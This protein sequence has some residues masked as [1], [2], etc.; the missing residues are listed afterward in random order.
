MKKQ[1]SEETPHSPET[2]PEEEPF[3]YYPLPDLLPPGHTLVL[4]ARLGLLSHLALES[5]ETSQPRLVAQEQFSAS[6]LSVLQPLLAS[7][8]DYCPYEL[9]YASFNGTGT[10]E[11]AIERARLRLHEAQFAGT[12]DYEM[13][14]VR[15]ILSRTRFKLR[16]FRLDVRS[17][18]ETGY[19]LKPLLGHT[20]ID[21]G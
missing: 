8:P 14:P 16:A 17:I 15:N 9:L 12:W 13:R 4:N 20:T 3:T 5:D 1:S 10:T 2:G 11:R 18:L 19:L 6:E 7:Y 21:Q